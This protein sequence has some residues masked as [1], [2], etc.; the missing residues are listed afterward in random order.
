VAR[1]ARDLQALTPARKPRAAHAGARAATRSERAVPKARAKST[2]PGQLR[3]THPER[4]VFPANGCTKG[5]VV[6]YYRSVAPFLLNEISGRPLSILRCPDG[7][8]KVC[9]FQKHMKP[10]MGADVHGVPIRDSSGDAE[11]LCI[12]DAAG[13]LELV[14]RNVIEFHPWGARS[15]NPERAD[16]IVFDLDPHA[17]VAWPRV[18]VAAKRLHD[19][20]AELGLE[21]FLRTSG[22]KGLHVVV[23]L[24]PAAG[25]DAVKAFAKSF[26]DAMTAKYPQDFVA[27]AGQNKRQGKIFIDW[28]RNYRGSTSVASYSLRARPDGGVAMPLAWSQLA[29]L[30]RATQYDIRNAAAYVRRRRSDPW[31]GIDAVRQ[32]LPRARR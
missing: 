7:T 15:K 17:S 22:G 31:A 20:L 27:T 18:R 21:S 8:A 26:A 10:N 13:L 9:F 19:A 4:V 30:A 12:G 3:I 28:L 2:D 5:D 25:W 16:R 6:R 11:Y 32:S 1:P 29:K 14:Q 24:K 23:P